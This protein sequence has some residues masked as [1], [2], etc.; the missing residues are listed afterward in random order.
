MLSTFACLS[1]VS[2]WPPPFCFIGHLS[3]DLEAFGKALQKQT[4]EKEDKPGDG[5]EKPKDDEEGMHLD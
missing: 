3:A 4:G 5:S 1:A 2:N